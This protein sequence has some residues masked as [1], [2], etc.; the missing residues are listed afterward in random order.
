MNII[1]SE[2]KNLLEA[3]NYRLDEAEGQIS[4]LNNKMT[5]ST[6]RENEKEN[7]QEKHE[8]PKGPLG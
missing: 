5:V 7:R 1:V 4:K 8:K 3:S 2:M 6:Q